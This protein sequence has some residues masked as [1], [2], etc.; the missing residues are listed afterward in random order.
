MR[1]DGSVRLLGVRIVRDAAVSGLLHITRAGLV[2]TMR[3]T[4]PGVLA[5][6]LQVRLTESG[7][8]RARG[9]LSGRRVDFTFRL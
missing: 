5:G 8:S 3:L 9:T 2:G 6:Q 1:R 7:S 4:G